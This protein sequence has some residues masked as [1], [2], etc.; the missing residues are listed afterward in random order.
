MSIC[1]IWDKFKLKLYSLD[2]ATYICTLRPVFTVLAIG[3]DTSPEPWPC[4]L[5]YITAYLTFG[6]LFVAYSAIFIAILTVK[7]YTLPFVDFKGLL[8]SG[9]YRFIT[10]GQPAYINL[11]QVR[12]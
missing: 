10:P 9:T 1:A 3:H 8:D 2:T 6:I 7:H 4:R 11:F 12:N 5:V